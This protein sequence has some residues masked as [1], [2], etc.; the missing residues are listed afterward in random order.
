MSESVLSVFF[1]LHQ[2]SAVV[3]I[4][5]IQKWKNKNKKYALYLYKNICEAG[6]C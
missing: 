3:T 6:M 1:L 5:V 2:N 4:Q